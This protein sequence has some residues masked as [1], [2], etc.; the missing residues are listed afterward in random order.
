MAVAV[1]S[2]LSHQLTRRQCNY[3]LAAAQTGSHP[4]LC[5]PH[6]H[7]N[8]NAC[9]HTHTRMHARTHTCTHAR[10]HAR[11]HAHAHT[12]V[13]GIGM[14]TSTS[15][16]WLRPVWAPLSGEC[17]TTKCNLAWAHH[18]TPACTCT[19]CTLLVHLTLQQ[20]PYCSGVSV[21]GTE[22]HT[23][24]Q[25][26]RTRS[27]RQ[28]LPYSTHPHLCTHAAYIH[29]YMYHIHSGSCRQLTSPKVTHM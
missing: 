26:C 1:R 6:T 20:C 19:S 27:C 4:H 16:R 9:T 25:T 21:A 15:C 14:Y 17:S 11:M 23:A 2:I 5:T 12:H 28:P 18:I 13:I 10:T 22:V 8:T 24:Q 29:W 7:A 3:T